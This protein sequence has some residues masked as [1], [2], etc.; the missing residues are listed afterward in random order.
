[1]SVAVQALLV[2][3]LALALLLRA[4]RNVAPVPPSPASFVVMRDPRDPSTRFRLRRVPPALWVT[5]WV[6]LALLGVLG[7]AGSRGPHPPPHRV[8]P[9]SVPGAAP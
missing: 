6:G 7:V 9:P 8:P 4:F 3:G 1:V 2:G 5:A